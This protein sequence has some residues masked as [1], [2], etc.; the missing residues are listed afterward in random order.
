MKVHFGG[1]G[2]GIRR[3]NLKYLLIRTALRKLGCTLAR[4]WLK[5]SVSKRTLSSE[6]AFTETIKAINNSDAVILEGTFDTS[7]VGKQLMVALN[8]ELPVLILYYKKLNGKSSLDK[9]IDKDSAKLVKRA[10]YDER[11]IKVKLN[12]F[13]DWAGNNTKIVRFNLELERRLDNYLKELAKR[14]NTSKSEEIRKLILKELK[15][16]KH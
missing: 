16:K 10:V 1:S 2:A 11:N 7:S 3:I 6:V 9:F 4:D 12:E 5:P 15:G 8:L 13:L 14:N